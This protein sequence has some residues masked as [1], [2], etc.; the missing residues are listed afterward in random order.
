MSDQTLSRAPDQSVDTARP[1][2][3]RDHYAVQG[4]TLHRRLLLLSLGGMLVSPLA[5]AQRTS[6]L[7]R[8]GVLIGGANDEGN[9]AELAALRQGL[10]E[11]GWTEG[12][13][14]ELDLRWGEGRIAVMRS[15]ADAIVNGK[16]DAIAVSTATAL[17]EVQR[18]A[19]DTPIVF[20]GVSDPVG[21]KFVRDLARPDGNTT[22]FSLF[23]YEMGGMWLKLLKEVSPALKRV[24]VLMHASN[25]NWPGWQRALEA[26]AP[27]QGLEL[28]K[29]VLVEEAQI[30][31]AVVAFAREGGGGMLVLP[32]PFLTPPSRAGA[33]TG[34]AIRHRLPSVYGVVKYAAAGGLMTYGPDQ[35][36]LARRAAGYVSRI[37][38]GEKPSQLPVQRPVRFEFVV[39]MR[40]ARA[41][42]LRIPQSIL[43]RAD[44]VIE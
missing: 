13:N 39:N 20:W 2:P 1:D 16:P 34:A 29:P 7:R 6:A 12:S 4:P 42:N 11:L 10:R 8:V 17:R 22:G 3:M 30:E 15:Q 25:P 24:L 14:I 43:L 28:S 41:L 23:E 40:T 37:L 36:D 9:N 5:R 18:A 21:N 31:P 26:V 19:G 38:R 27:V 32:D 44:Q 33:I 35:A